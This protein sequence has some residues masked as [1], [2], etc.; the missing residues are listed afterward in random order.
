MKL[1]EIT[2]FNGKYSEK[3]RLLDFEVRPVST[4]GNTTFGR[5]RNRSCDFGFGEDDN[6]A[7]VFFSIKENQRCMTKI[8]KTNFQKLLNINLWQ[9]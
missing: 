2:Y 4:H 9:I 5:F 6:M 7:V 3:A 1:K 8:N